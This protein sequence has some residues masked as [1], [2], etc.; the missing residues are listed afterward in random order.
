MA[1]LLLIVALL[2]VAGNA[3]AVLNTIQVPSGSC[4]DPSTTYLQAN[5][6][7]VGLGV[8]NPDIPFVAHVNSG[9]TLS[10]ECVTPIVTAGGGEEAEGKGRG[11]RRGK[12]KGE[13][14]EGGGERKE[15]I[16]LT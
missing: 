11:K 3:A 13:T 10:I 2:S 16:G 14:K 15:S 4:A 1:T 8:Y 12:K 7:T 5:S 6:K 9:D